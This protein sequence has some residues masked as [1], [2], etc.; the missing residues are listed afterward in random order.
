MLVLKYG[1]SHLL[2]T[3]TGP[4][5]AKGEQKISASIMAS[6]EQRSI[7]K[8]INR[9]ESLF[10]TS[11]LSITLQNDGSCLVKSS[12]LNNIMIWTNLGW[13]KLLDSTYAQA[14]SE[15]AIVVPSNSLIKVDGK[16]EHITF[17]LSNKAKRSLSLASIKASIK[18]AY[19]PFAGSIGVHLLLALMCVLIY[20]FDLNL[21]NLFGAKEAEMAVTEIEVTPEVEKMLKSG[22]ASAAGDYAG[23]MAWK[24]VSAEDMAKAQADRAAKIT[25]RVSGLAERLS[26][27]DLSGLKI[28]V[29]NGS[30]SGDISAALGKVGSQGGVG[31]GQGLSG[32][33]QS[34]G[35]GKIG[36]NMQWN[37]VGQAG[38]SISNR[39]QEMLVRAMRAL[40]D[41]FRDCYEKALLIDES[42]AVTVQM[43]AVVLSSG[44]LANPAYEIEGR[45]T[46]QSESSLTA[47]MTKVLSTVKA[48]KTLVG[49][50]V[51]NQIIFK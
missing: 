49:V 46:P 34:L 21:W 42:M 24:T 50:T 10:L 48:G 16:G 6:G 17:G 47:C 19:A 11:Q 36:G 32:R 41:D 12:G 26:R 4:Y 13:H 51:K 30:M 43:A 37:L 23:S 15:Y 38:T 20:K 2:Q 33:I 8:V 39:D 27:M 44:R 28:K 35:A 1:I 7:Q 18:E 5:Q 31:N 29:G 22:G 25:S 40:Q 45:S 3:I 14:Q 9:G